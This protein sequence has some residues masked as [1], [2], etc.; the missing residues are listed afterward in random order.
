MLMDL[1]FVLKW[2]KSVKSCVCALYIPSPW[3]KIALGLL[4]GSVTRKKS[5]NVYK[6][7]P[8]MISLIIQCSMDT[9]WK[10]KARSGLR[11]MQQRRPFLLGTCNKRSELEKSQWTL[12]SDPYKFCFYCSATHV[13]SQVLQPKL[14]NKCY[15]GRHMV[16][17]VHCGF[18]NK[19]L[20]NLKD[21]DV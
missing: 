8:K 15:R 18:R 20:N 3:Y 16:I 14:V 4:V 19:K 9:R 2:I 1:V 6:I 11:K 5:P 12:I 21:G 17:S 10:T 7:C 13:K